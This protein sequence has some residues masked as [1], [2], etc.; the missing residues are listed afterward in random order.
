MLRI[1]PVRAGGESYYFRTVAE[2][3]DRPDGLIEA[4]PQWLGTGLAELDIG[5]QA[6]TVARFAEVEA[7]FS[8][9]PRASTVA[10]DVVLSVPKSVSIVHALGRP[11]AVAAMQDAHQA[12]VEET[13]AYIERELL[14]VW[15][16]DGGSRVPV[17]PEG[18]VAVAFLHRTSRSNDPHLHTHLLVAN[19]GRTPD[20]R[21]SS[22]DARLL[23]KDQRVVRAL[24]ETELRYQL[25]SRVIA[26]GP[27][28]GVWADLAGVDRVVVE[29]FSKRS[30]TITKGDRRRPGK[31]REIGYEDL[32]AGWQQEGF[33]LSLSATRLAQAGGAPAGTWVLDGSG[34]EELPSF[35]AVIERAADPIRGSFGKAELTIACCA[36]SEKGAP[37]RAIEQQVSRI[38]DDDAVIEI[39]P[40]G[41]TGRHRSQARFVTRESQERLRQA[42]T[43]V[44][45][46]MGSS[47]LQLC[48][49]EARERLGALDRVSAAAWQAARDGRRLVAVAPGHKAAQSFEATTGIETLSL[50]RVGEL[51]ER[52]NP[53]DEL[54]LADCQHASEA[55]LSSVLSHCAERQVL[56]VLFTSNE[57]LDK[58]PLLAEARSL[59]LARDLSSDL[60]PDTPLWRH[61]FCLGSKVAVAETPRVA[62]EHVLELA[63]A[64]ARSTT[65]RQ[66][67]VVVPD[68]VVA[69]DLQS[70]LAERIEEPK[71]RPLV[72]SPSELRS[73]IERPTGQLPALIVLGGAARLGL[74]AELLNRCERTHVLVAPVPNAG[75]AELLP[76]A[77]DAVRPR[78]L[79]SILHAVPKDQL[80]RDNWRETAA[81]VERF[82]IRHGLTG[83]PAP[84]GSDRAEVGS[85]QA[86]E[87][88][89]VRADVEVAV[90]ALRAS[91]RELRKERANE[92]SLGAGRACGLEGSGGLTGLGR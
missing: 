18:A 56:A 12:A 85:M 57:A 4:D 2:T 31:D 52:L 49:F 16:S 48:T 46:M 21:W 39:G 74:G 63:V 73:M 32:Q 34:L 17:Q 90:G 72:T 27:I 71:A 1:A 75:E 40:Y 55:E 89:D 66:T 51:F 7:V 37:I 47:D 36:L 42:A 77:C 26:L 65:D 53:G 76:P 22:V 70:E 79:V 78:H 61:D 87:E 81:K 30:R 44:G 84:F 11:E 8:T 59:A 83:D 5:V 64:G 25:S 60:P 41:W 82:R 9:L 28:Q 67:I 54:V 6:H 62:R 23:Y 45:E 24:F 19:L 86:L 35:E 88:I 68:R 13:L 58:S 69:M 50:S 10:H 29:A 20:G 38:L 43:R 15:R 14:V 33:A 91:R 3:S 92:R 80:S